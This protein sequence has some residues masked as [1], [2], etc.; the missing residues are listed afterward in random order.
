M[1]RKSKE[2]RDFILKNTANNPRT[3]GVLAAEKFGVTRAAISRHLNKLIQ[4][5]LLEASGSTRD[6]SYKLKPTFELNFEVSLIPGVTEE[7]YYWT[8]KVY[9]HVKDLP[10]NVL[11][12]CEYGFQEILNNAI[13]HSEA[14]K[15][16]V[17]ITRNAVMATMTVGD[18]GVGIFNKIQKAFDLPDARQAA[19]ELSKG[20][21]TTH[22][23]EHTGYGIFFVSRMFDQFGIFSGSVELIRVNEEDNWIFESD[24]GEETE[25]TVVWMDIHYDA[26]QTLDE[27]FERYGSEQNRLAF[28]KTHVSLHLLRYE[29]EELVSRS[30]ARRL[31]ARVERFGEVIL[32]FRGITTIGHSFAD[33]IFRVFKNKHPEIKLIPIETTKKI[34]QIIESVK[35][36]DAIMK[37]GEVQS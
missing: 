4:D 24:Q 14:T 22:Q 20:R 10:R 6:R 27:I 26:P 1:A 32:D 11:R 5:G 8:H 29:G 36:A 2:I 35:V 7:S 31:L 18:F 12:I 25:G 34:D 19:F 3:V 13:N 17:S 16:I 15:A 33:E 30:Q 21:L 37:Q 28:I 9:E 23:Q